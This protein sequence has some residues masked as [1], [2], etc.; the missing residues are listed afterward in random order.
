MLLT[1]KSHLTAVAIRSFAI[2]VGMG[3]SLTGDLLLDD[4]RLH[5][6]PIHD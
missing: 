4:V 5:E 6:I 2:E 1:H 3:A